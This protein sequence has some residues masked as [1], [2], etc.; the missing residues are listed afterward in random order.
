MSN[1]FTVLL[2]RRG[3]WAMFAAQMPSLL[4]V[5][6]L[7]F[8]TSVNVLNNCITLMQVGRGITS[9]MSALTRLY[10]SSLALL[11]Q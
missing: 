3:Q 6:K 1:L 7:T 9:P 2:T 4:C 8:Y 5:I 11:Q 10:I